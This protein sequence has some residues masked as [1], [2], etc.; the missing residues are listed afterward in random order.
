MR[1]ITV[2]PGIGDSARL[3]DVPEPSRAEG[4]LL[5]RSL[6]LGVC[7]TDHHIISGEY[8]EP[9]PG[10]ERLILGH[11]SLGIVEDAPA[12]TGRPGDHVVGIV[13]R[14]DPVPCPAC[15]AGEWDL[16]RNGRYTERGIKGR[17][18]FGSERFRLEPGFA[19]QVAPALG[20]AAV[21]LEPASI[22]A[23][24]W[25]HVERIGRRM[26]SWR[27][28]KLL[29]TGA[30]PVGLLAALMGVQRRLQVH[31]FD[32]N[33]SGA[34]PARVDELGARYH[35]AADVLDSLRPDIVLEC[36]GAPEVVHDVLGRT[37]PDGIVCL[38]GV[39]ADRTLELDLGRVNRTMVIENHTVFG[40]VNANRDHYAAALSALTRADRG[41]LDRL[42]T[43]RVPLARWPEALERRP[44]DIK[45]IIDFT[46]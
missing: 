42:I 26:R 7:G 8:G 31:M 22:V 13:R 38:L 23:K 24:A 30:G 36:T 34:K 15:A 44:D 16:C 6:A 1:A 25:D 4:S 37:A 14:P 35:H 11:E 18:G 3:E 21:L 43:R 20:L 27:P 19:I 32:R 39:S 2:T 17:H 40:A 29:V 41:W 12:G 9:P 45:V 28:E 33:P 10:V 46:R 5:V